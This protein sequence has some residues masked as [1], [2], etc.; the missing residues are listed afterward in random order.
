M[1]R[2][3]AGKGGGDLAGWSERKKVGAALGAALIAGGVGL[4]VAVSVRPR[5]TAS[6]KR[7]F[8]LPPAVRE[9]VRQGGTGAAA[10][11]EGTQLPEYLAPS[12][13]AS[14]ASGSGTRKVPTAALSSAAPQELSAAALEPLDRLG[15][16]YLTADDAVRHAG[17]K[18][19]QEYGAALRSLTA[20]DA[21]YKGC[22]A[23]FG[24]TLRERGIEPTSRKRP[25]RLFAAYLATSREAV[26]LLR[27]YLKNPEPAVL[28]EADTRGV[29]AQHGRAA[30]VAE[31]T[32]APA[33]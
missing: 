9:R 8:A 33:K 5:R 12:G 22:E 26:D 28:E 29:E 20:Y 1:G 31:L 3:A 30:L 16:A 27:R 32:E 13:G 6:E 25:A 7:G 24:K 2:G 21:A 10:E 14:P 11:A 19:S 15:M 23:A 18:G 17:P 4:A